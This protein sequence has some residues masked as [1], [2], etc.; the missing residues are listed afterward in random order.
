MRLGIASCLALAAIPMMATG[1]FFDGGATLAAGT[2]NAA[3]LGGLLAGK[4]AGLAGAGL[5]LGGRG[6]SN[7]GHHYTTSYHRPSYSRSYRHKREADP[8]FFDGGL[9][10]AAG[11]ANAAVLGGLLA[12]KLAGLAGAGLL[13]G[14]RGRSNRGRHYSSS[15][16][17]PSYRRSSYRH[18]RE[19]DPLFFD[20][21]LTVA[22]GTANAAVLGGLLAGKLAG[23]AG[24]ALLFGGRG[25]S[26]RG[27]HYSSSYYRPSYRRSYRHKR[28]EPIEINVTALLEA[29]FLD[30]A[31]QNTAGC[32]QRLFCDMSADPSKYEEQAPM[33]VA[34]RLASGVEFT[35]PKANEVVQMLNQAISRGESTA[36]FKT[37]TARVSM[38][39]ATYNKCQW[40]GNQMTQAISDLM[41]F[42][43][44]KINA[45]IV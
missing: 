5:L 37:P 13:L 43:S 16:Y 21:G 38:C 6:R 31:E 42:E 7:R 25:R 39:E 36:T 4:L 27:R 34:A 20:G 29:T 44:Q 15:Y 12:G 9:T 40:T 35:N 10:V 19:A 2:A 18:K 26:N 22:A 28:E 17:R 32:F 11:T 23:L 8:L 45:N 3:V 1:L 24:G 30:M 33:M 14:G 41:Q